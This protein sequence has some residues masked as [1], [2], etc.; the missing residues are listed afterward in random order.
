VEDA[1]GQDVDIDIVVQAGW[2]FDHAKLSSEYAG[3]PGSAVIADLNARCD[4]GLSESDLDT[5]GSSNWA[6]ISNDLMISYFEGEGAEAPDGVVTHLY[7]KGAG[8]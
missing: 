1:I 3:V 5:N 6:K 7:S 2:N 4:L 8:G